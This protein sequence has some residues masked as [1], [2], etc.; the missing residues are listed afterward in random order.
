MLCVIWS[1]G[2]VPNLLLF[3]VVSFGEE[4]S[5]SEVKVG[6]KFNR[7]QVWDKFLY[8]MYICQCAM[9]SDDVQSRK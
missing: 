6:D 3:L 5:H 9:L 8:V 1:F 4:L 7:L 2:I